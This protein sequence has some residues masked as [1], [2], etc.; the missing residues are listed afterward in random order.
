MHERDTQ[1]ALLFVERLN[2]GGTDYAQFIKDLLGH[3]RDVYVVKHTGEAPP[4]I[5]IT[6]EQLARAAQPGFP[7][8]DGARRSPS[9][10]C[11]E[12]RCAPSAR[13]PTPGWSWNWS[14]SR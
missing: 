13:G 7:G 6:E 4:S 8:V 5:A 14:S 10:T 1:G 9:S 11:W 3:L 2:Q 12:K